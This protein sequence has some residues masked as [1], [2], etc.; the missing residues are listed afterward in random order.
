[1]RTE[2]SSLDYD[3]RYEQCLC[4][5]AE[6]VAELVSLVPRVFLVISGDEQAHLLA[7]IRNPHVVPRSIEPAPGLV[8]VRGRSRRAAV[9]IFV[10]QDSKSRCEIATA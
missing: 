7:R 5:I 8:H 6:T 4:L 9:F 3:S 1:M 10:S 2:K